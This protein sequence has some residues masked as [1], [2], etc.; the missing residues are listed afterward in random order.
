VATATAALYIFIIYI[1]QVKYPSMQNNGVVAVVVGDG[2]FNPQVTAENEKEVREY[3]K[4]DIEF[5]RFKTGEDYTNL[6]STVK[7]AEYTAHY[8]QM[9][10]AIHQLVE[11]GEVKAGRSAWLEMVPIPFL[12]VATLID[13]EWLDRHVLMLAE[14]GAMIADKGYQIQ[15]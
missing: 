14:A 2:K 5:E 3:F 8:D 7:D 1:G 13:G 11:S 4:D 10:H 12:Q 15:E 9:V 6:L